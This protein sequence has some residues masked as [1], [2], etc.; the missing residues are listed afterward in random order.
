MKRMS[1][2]TDVHSLDTGLPEEEIIDRKTDMK[3]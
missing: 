2:L 1:Q 3:K